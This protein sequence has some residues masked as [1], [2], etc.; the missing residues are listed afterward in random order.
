MEGMGGDAGGSSEGGR[1][2]P[3][4]IHQ[5]LQAERILRNLPTVLAQVSRLPP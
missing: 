4:G 2:V 3:H 1:H 5:P